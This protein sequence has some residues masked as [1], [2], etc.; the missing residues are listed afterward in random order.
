VYKRWK[1]FI[2]WKK[3]LRYGKMQHAAE[4]IEANLFFFSKPLRKT[5]LEVRSMCIPLNNMGMLSLPKGEI[6]KL[7]DFVKVQ[8]VVHAELREKV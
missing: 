7:N 1:S 5:L 4:H 6:F 3:G 2:V 8:E